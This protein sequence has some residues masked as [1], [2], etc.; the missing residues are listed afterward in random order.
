MKH[1]ENYM[2]VWIYDMAAYNTLYDL[3]LRGAELFII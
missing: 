3:S 1:T 2:E